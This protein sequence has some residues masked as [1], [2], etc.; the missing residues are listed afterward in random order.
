[1]LRDDRAVAHRFLGQSRYRS[2]EFVYEG[3]STP[4]VKDNAHV[5]RELVDDNRSVCLGNR[6]P[7]WITLNDLDSPFRITATQF[8][9]NQG[10]DRAVADHR[11]V[12]CRYG[13]PSRC[14]HRD[15]QRHSQHRDGRVECFGKLMNHRLGNRD[16]LREAAGAFKTQNA[17]AQAPVWIDG[18][19]RAPAARK[20]RVKHDRL[21]R[22]KI[23]DPSP[24]DVNLADNLTS[25]HGRPCDDPGP[26]SQYPLVSVA[27][28]RPADTDPNLALTRRRH[29]N[30][31]NPERQI[32]LQD[33]CL[34]LTAH[35]HSDSL[36]A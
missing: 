32:P 34:G 35:R 31:A 7:G 36:A 9:M 19:G 15:R 29:R 33:Q 4:G 23:N 12:A 17:R 10:A 11:N 8:Q 2:R 22:H 26:G 13:N 24:H 1:M 21:A 6:R 3:C 5:V 25:Q 27:D 14:M 18:A 28:T 20:S 30:L 16:Q